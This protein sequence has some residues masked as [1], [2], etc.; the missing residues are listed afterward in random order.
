[1]IR[2]L[3]NLYVPASFVIVTLYSCGVANENQSE[4]SS[5]ASFE[6]TTK[7]SNTF[8]KRSLLT[9]TSLEEGRGGEYCTLYAFNKY[10]LYAKPIKD[11]KH[12]KVNIVDFTESG[13]GFSSGYVYSEHVTFESTEKSLDMKPNTEDPIEED[14]TVRPNKDSGAKIVNFMGKQVVI[15]VVKNTSLS[16]KERAFLDMIA[17]AEGTSNTLSPCGRAD[18]GYQSIFGCDRSSSNL[19]Y[20]YGAHP[21][22]AYATGW[23]TYSDAAGRY[24]FKSTTWKELASKH[25]ISDFSPSS[26]DKG[27]IL[28]VQERGANPNAI[29]SLESFNNT[30]YSLRLEWASMPHSPYGQKTYDA[31]PLYDLYLQALALY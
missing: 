8:V 26:Q 13:C 14:L 31:K 5:V 1:M 6:M 27:A 2:N 30:V 19:F 20:S 18:K 7:A 25:G 15:G 28:K 16:A 10:K 24:Q 4:L 22:R 23:G 12:F 11:G 3:F 17:A 9:D 21:E 29:S